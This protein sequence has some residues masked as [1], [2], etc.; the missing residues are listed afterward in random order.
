MDILLEEVT[1]VLVTSVV[2][3]FVDTLEMTVLVSVAE[4]VSW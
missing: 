4:L 2:A 1:C 3:S